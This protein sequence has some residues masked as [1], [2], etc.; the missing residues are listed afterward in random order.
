MS[1]VSL[2]VLFIKC[3]KHLYS[4]TI[5]RSILSSFT[6]GYRILHMQYGCNYYHI[7]HLGSI[8]YIYVGATDCSCPVTKRN[9]H[10]ACY[11]GLPATTS[12]IGKASAWLADLDRRRRQWPISDMSV[13]QVYLKCRTWILKRN[14]KSNYN[15]HWTT[16]HD[17]FNLDNTLSRHA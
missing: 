2:I 13:I 7:H 6:L 1:V 5:F 3:P 10:Y 4:V 14:T 9:G 8:I 17:T 11:Q 12:T 15:N 16:E